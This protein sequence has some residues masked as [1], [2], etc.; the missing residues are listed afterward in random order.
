MGKW[1]GYH[2]EFAHLARGFAG[3][4]RALAQA[5]G[6]SLLN[7]GLLVEKPCVGQR[8]VCLNPRRAGEIHGLVDAASCRAALRLRVMLAAGDPRPDVGTKLFTVQ[9][10]REAGI[11]ARRGPTASCARS[12]ALRA[13]GH[14]VRGAATA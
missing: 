11:A 7:A 5:M 4:D 1:G 8:H 14:D 2:T 9:T 12:S 3:H 13:L 10:L 6:E